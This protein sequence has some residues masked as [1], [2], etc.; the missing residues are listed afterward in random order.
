MIAQAHS[1]AAHSE[2][3]PSLIQYVHSVSKGSLNISLIL[4]FVAAKR[5]K[6]Y[7]NNF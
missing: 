5:E 1:Q 2:I 3:D 6:P 7:S 4:E